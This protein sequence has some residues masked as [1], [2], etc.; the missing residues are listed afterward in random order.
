MAGSE[1]TRRPVWVES[2]SPAV[3]ARFDRE[4]PFPLHFRPLEESAD[5]RDP[6]VVREQ[7]SLVAPTNLGLLRRQ[8]QVMAESTR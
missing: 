7:K 2:G 3:R 1:K 8:R 6:L 5:R 4:P